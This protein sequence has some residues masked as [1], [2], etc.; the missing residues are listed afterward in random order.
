MSRAY[1]TD[2]KFHEPTELICPLRSYL[3]SGNSPE[4][5]LFCGVTSRR[6]SVLL[7]CQTARH[8][9]RRA[10]DA[11]RKINAWRLCVYDGQAF[12]IQAFCCRL[13]FV[14]FLFSKYFIQY[15]LG[16]KIEK[17]EMGEV[18]SAYGERSGV[19]GVLVGNLRERD[20][21]E[22]PVV[23]GRIIIKMDLQEVGC[24][25]MDWIELTQD[26][27]RCREIVNVVMN[28]WVP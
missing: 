15:C 12:S 4:S 26:R 22:D 16:D 25:G 21:L 11:L 17:N 20:H 10:Q 19:Y 13:C 23:D 27:D 5:I 28:F 7:S 2:M 24:G 3:A 1:R 18:C 8:P 6:L 9:T 14:Y